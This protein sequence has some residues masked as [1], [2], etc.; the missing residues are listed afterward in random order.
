MNNTGTIHSQAFDAYTWGIYLS[1]LT[2][3]A[4]LINSGNIEI[5][6]TTDGGFD[7]EQIGNA[8]ATGIGINM[9]NFSS[10]PKPVKTE[11]IL[12]SGSSLSVSAHAVEGMENEEEVTY[13]LCQAIQLQKI[14]Y[15]GDPGYEVKP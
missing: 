10:D 11:L 3:N 14:Y 1:N 9:D 8:C 6:A 2:D 7:G 5:E 13:N 15:G 12:E 4:A